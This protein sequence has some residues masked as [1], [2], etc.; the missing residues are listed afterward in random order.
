M[1][2]DAYQRA[3]VP[4]IVSITVV[5]H[6]TLHALLPQEH[7]VD[8]RAQLDEA[9]RRERSWLELHG[10]RCAPCHVCNPQAAL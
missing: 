3:A 8:V 5:T 1:G 2:S 7:L 10:G 4:D 6:V 9:L